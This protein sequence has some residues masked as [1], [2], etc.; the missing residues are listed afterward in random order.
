MNAFNHSR[1]LFLS[2]GQADKA[3]AKKPKKQ[4]HKKA[5]RVFHHGRKIQRSGTQTETLLHADSPLS[6]YFTLI[7]TS[8]PAASI[9]KKCKNNIYTICEKSRAL[10]T[11]RNALIYNEYTF[12]KGNRIK[13]QFFYIHLSILKGSESI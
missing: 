9:G 8:K 5:G 12:P 2:D 3:K 6:A 11:L 7:I 10:L 13:I 1:K 4:P